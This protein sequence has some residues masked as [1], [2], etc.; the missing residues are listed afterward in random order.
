MQ[1]LESLWS[2]TLLLPGRAQVTGRDTVNTMFLDNPSLE[3]YH[4]LLY[5][6]PYATTLQ[7]RW[8]GSHVPETV[9]V[10]RQVHREG[11]QPEECTE[12]SFPIQETRVGAGRGGQSGSESRVRG[13]NE[14]CWVGSAGGR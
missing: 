7:L 3:L 8:Y 14:R 5:G 10:I 9:E 2:F 4:S 11:W 12:D 1:L 6:R 13:E